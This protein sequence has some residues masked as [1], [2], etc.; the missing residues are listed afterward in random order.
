MDYREMTK[1]ASDPARVRS[2]AKMVLT[3]E[4]ERLSE[5]AQNLLAKLSAYDGAKPLSTRQQEALYA[6]R[7]QASR[8][9]NVGP[10]RAADLVAKAW[11]RR[12]DLDQFEDEAW[13][14]ELRAK[15]SVISLSRNEARRLLAICRH[16]EID[17]IPPGVWIEL[18]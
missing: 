16:P 5:G 9:A 10:Y 18:A 14:D 15:G 17:L 8:S 4:A 6:L 2:L 12:F 7:E 11:E 1:L 13:L 3:L